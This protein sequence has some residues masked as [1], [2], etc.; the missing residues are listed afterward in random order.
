MKDAVVSRGKEPIKLAAALLVLALVLVL[1]I[2]PL[3]TAKRS[4][5][6]VRKPARPPI[7]SRN[8]GIAS[9]SATTPPVDLLSQ[10]GSWSGT[11]DVREV[12]SV[13]EAGRRQGGR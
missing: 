13:L 4:V 5:V 1:F 7:V 3:F 2:V 11:E 8:A 6:K 9:A 12:L 10:Y